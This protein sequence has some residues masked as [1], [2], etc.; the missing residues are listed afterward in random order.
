MGF[1]YTWGGAGDIPVQGDYDGDGKTDIAVFRP[2]TGTWYI[3]N[4][5]TGMGFTYTWGGAGDIPVPGDY[6]GDGKTDIA[7]FRPSTGVWYIIRSSTSMGFTYTW[8]GGG[9]IPVPGDYDGDGKTDIAVFRPSTGVWYI[10]RSSTSMGS[11]Y[12]WGGGSDIAVPGDYDGDGKID[13][14]VFRPSTGG[15]FILKSSTNYTSWDT[16]R[17]GASTDVAILV[18]MMSAPQPVSAGPTPYYGSPVAIPGTIAAEN[19]DEGGEGI[20]Y[21]DST[22]GNSGGAYRMTDVDIERSSEGAYDV[23]WTTPGE[24]LNYSVTV[25]TAANYVVQLRLATPAAGRSLHIGFNGSGVWTVVPIPATGA[26]Q[27]WT[28]VNVPVTLAAGPQLLTVLFDTGGVNLQSITVVRGTVAVGGSPVVV[29]WNIENIYSE[30]HARAAMDYLTALSPT[31]E[32]IVIQEAYQEHFAAFVDELQRRTGK[33][34]YGAFSTHCPPA[35][36]NGTTCTISWSE[37][38]GIF[39]TFPIV[40]SST[41]WFPFPDCWTSARTGLRAALDVGGETLQVFALHLQTGGC[42]NAAQ[43]RYNSMASF[44]QWASQ[45]SAPQIVGGD[46]N[47]DPD[48]IA[49]AAGMS[50]NFVDSWSVVGSGR[51]L[52]SFTPAPT[53]KLDYLFADASAKAQP[54]WSNVVTTTGT[55]SDHYPLAAA[56]VIRP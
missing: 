26:W 21:H 2:S 32:I 47:A 14:A 27:T 30:G 35:G 50:G 12:N 1:T 3:V 46:F 7:V 5:S 28:T 13:L 55:V 52:T 53:M 48:Q 18:N 23:G 56:F 11:T 6:D 42:S 16:C 33:V 49:S 40:Q 41:A 39:S 24:W 44:K 29:T 45:Y 38:V 9:D 25:A 51:G 15:W 4:S 36:W 10:I 17:W 34:W 19:F 20:A 8:G 54:L 31:P 43:A 37:G 22:P